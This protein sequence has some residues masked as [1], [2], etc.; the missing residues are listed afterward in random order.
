MKLQGRAPRAGA[1]LAAVHA[2]APRDGG[3]NCSAAQHLPITGWPPRGTVAR[4]GAGC[5]PLALRASGPLRRR[6]SGAP[7]GGMAKSERYPTL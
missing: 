4:R 3:A 6:D 7:V 2:K 5:L 1:G